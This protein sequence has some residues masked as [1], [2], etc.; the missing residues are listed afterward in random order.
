MEKWSLKKA[1]AGFVCVF[2]LPLLMSGAVN[3]KPVEFNAVTMLPRGN[4]I[5]KS[6][7]IF[8]NAFNEKFKGEAIIN[9]RGG[10][11]IIS[12]FQQ[13]EAVRSGAMD[14]AATSG[15]YYTSLLPVSHS[16]MYSNKTHEEMRGA[17]F[18]EVFE[19]AHRDV[20]LVYLCEISY[21]RKFYLYIND[22]IK[23]PK[24]LAGEK[25]RVFPTIAPFVKA[26]G[27]APV[28]MPITEIYS[29]ME[30]GVV[31]GFGM[32]VAGF[33]KGW[34]WHE[35]TKYMIEP[36]FYRATIAVLVNPKK[37]EELSPNLQ[38]RIRDWK[39]DVF[40]LEAG[41]FYM[42]Q[43]KTSKRLILNNGVKAIEFSPADTK[44]YLKLAYDSAWKEVNK[45][46]PELGPK[47]Q[48]M[49]IK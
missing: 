29:A 47:L 12:G 28:N 49:L 46:A 6:F 30:R 37:W 16:L 43:A 15:G 1:A 7:E 22:Q 34:S 21:G 45:Q 26:L 36:G 19:K 20:G 32:T 41:K 4:P 27:A 11:E 18:F 14:M 9:W 38:K 39:Y 48:R 44:A 31:D 3:A 13:H 8:S 25:I 2:A 5:M 33:V 40:D 35:V 17:G 10:P 42:N 23:T 24:D